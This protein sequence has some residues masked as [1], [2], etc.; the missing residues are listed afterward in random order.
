MDNSVWA[1][2][3]LS[4]RLLDGTGRIVPVKNKSELTQVRAV[5]LTE[6][7]LLSV[8]DGNKAVAQGEGVQSKGPVPA[9]KPGRFSVTG[10]GFPKLLNGELVEFEITIAAEQ[11]VM[12]NR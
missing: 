3:F 8:C 5:E 1:P 2:Q 11:I 12:I 6:A 9:A 4:V 7:T 10:L